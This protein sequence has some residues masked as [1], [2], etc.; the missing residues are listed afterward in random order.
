M[1]HGLSMSR[2]P[3]GGSPRSR[4]E[5]AFS[6]ASRVRSMS[7]GLWAKD[8]KAVSNWEGGRLTPRRS[9]AL[10]YRANR[11]VSQ[12]RA[13]E[14]S[15]T[16]RSLKKTVNMDPRRERLAAMPFFRKSFII[17][18]QRRRVFRSRSR[19]PRR[20]RERRGSPTPPPWQEGFPRGSPPD[21]RGPP[22]R[23]IP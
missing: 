15:V 2:L 5:R 11:P 19:N 20:S 21:T 16:S 12:R 3:A 9:M 4:K 6:Q 8:T 23:A 7:S 17:P 18:S 13:D 1:H 22:A 10:K 14:K